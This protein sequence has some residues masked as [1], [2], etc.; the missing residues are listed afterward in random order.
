MGATEAS[1]ASQLKVSRAEGGSEEE[2]GLGALQGGGLFIQ[3]GDKGTQRGLFCF[4]LHPGWIEPT[5]SWL[6]ML[7][8]LLKVRWQ[9]QKIGCG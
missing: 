4:K 5:D 6:H 9:V 8:G 1:L 7:M 3:T 2:S